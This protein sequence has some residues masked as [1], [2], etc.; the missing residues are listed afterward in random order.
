MEL[1]GE[2]GWEGDKSGGVV[3]VLG[4][5]RPVSH[6]FLSDVKM[7]SCYIFISSHFPSQLKELVSS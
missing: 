1:Q 4:L 5:D 2:L 6:S 7:A 3:G